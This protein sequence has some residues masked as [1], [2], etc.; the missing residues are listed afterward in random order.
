M[1]KTVDA[2][3]PVEAN[4]PKICDE[5]YQHIDGNVSNL[6]VDAGDL[7]L[8]INAIMGKDKQM[9]ACKSCGKTASKQRDMRIHIEGKHIEG[10]VYT[11]NICG[12]TRTS[13]ESMRL[14]V[15]R[16]HK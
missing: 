8:K 9:W 7:E 16:K 3:Y 6:N 13:K 11:C 5:N 14:H 10:V 15:S 2:N 4:I 1:G 12:N